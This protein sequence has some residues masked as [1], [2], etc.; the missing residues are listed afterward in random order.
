M[1]YRVTFD[2]LYPDKSES[3]EVYTCHGQS[4]AIVI[5]TEKHNSSNKGHILSVEVVHLDGKEPK[6]MD[7]V[8]R[9]E[10]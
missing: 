7:L 6:G 10:W 1:R 5:A 3:Y 8:D 9:M 4:K 2:L